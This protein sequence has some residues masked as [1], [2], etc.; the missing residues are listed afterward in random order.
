MLLPGAVV[1]VGAA[2]ALAAYVTD[3]HIKLA[4]GLI[5]LLACTAGGIIGVLAGDL[6]PVSWREWRVIREVAELSV[7]VRRVLLTVSTG[8]PVAAL[9]ILIH[10][11]TATAMYI[12]A[13]GLRMP[14]GLFDC[15]VLTPP[16]MLLSAVPI[17]IAGWGV[18]EA[19]TVGALAM[20]G[21]ATEPALAL[22]LLMGATTLANG[23]LGVVPLVLGGERLRGL[24]VLI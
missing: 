21:I 15:L 13:S 20:L 12:L 23:I 19:V 16:I 4:V 10:V 2:W 3:Y 5:A 1:G 24:R 7:A 22:S 18:R 9:A 6:L 17:S 14:L 8:V 11:L